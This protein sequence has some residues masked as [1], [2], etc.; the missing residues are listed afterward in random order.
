MIHYGEL[1]WVEIS[2]LVVLFLCGTI[3]NSLVLLVYRPRGQQRHQATVFFIRHLGEKRKLPRSRQVK[4]QGNLIRSSQYTE[5]NTRKKQ[6]KC[7]YPMS[8]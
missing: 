8:M 3:G 4:V 1:E 7:G 6:K 2:F 5:K